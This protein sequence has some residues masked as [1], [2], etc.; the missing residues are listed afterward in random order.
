MYFLVD[1]GA[2]ISIQ[3]KNL[4]SDARLTQKS[5]KLKEGRPR[6]PHQQPRSTR[7]KERR[8]PS[9]QDQE[10]LEGSRRGQ[11]TGESQGSRKLTHWRQGVHRFRQG[12]LFKL[13]YP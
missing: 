11:E 13:L 4:V 9:I 8:H 3:Q 7:M 10:E 6:R 1:S 5:V 12:K 2:D